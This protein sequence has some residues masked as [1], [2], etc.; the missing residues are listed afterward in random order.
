MLKYFDFSIVDLPP[1][2][3]G[4]YQKPIYYG[5]IHVISGFLGYYYIWFA[6][7]FIIYQLT[8]LFLNKRFFVF[9][10]RIEDGNSIGHTSFKL[11]E[12]VIGVIIGWIVHKTTKL[13][14]PKDRFN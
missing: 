1:N 14:L 6:V 2:K 10:L 5:L 11:A 8:Q 7:L 4:V 12:F 13:R 3:A 9:Q